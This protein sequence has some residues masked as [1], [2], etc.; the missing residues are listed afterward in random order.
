[1]KNTFYNPPLENVFAIFNYVP[2]DDVKVVLIGDM[3]YENRNDLSDIAFATNNAYPTELLKRIYVQLEDNVA[4]FKRPLINHLRTWLDQGIFLCNFCFTRPLTDP[5]PDHYYYLWEP[6]INNLVQ[7][8]SN[9]HPVLFLLMGSKA[10]TVKKS[11]NEIKSSVIEIPHPIYNYNDFKK[12]KCFREA[13]ERAT[14]LGFI[15]KW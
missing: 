14:E 15:I 9:H 5:V 13:C 4:S 6:F 2:L 11:I 1:M 12:S 10:M 8:I 3:P 7:Y